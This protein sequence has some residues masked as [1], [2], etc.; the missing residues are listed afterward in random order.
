MNNAERYNAADVLLA[1]NVAGERAQRVAVIDD[2]R[3]Y[4]YGELNERVNRFSNLLRSRD[5]AP[6]ERLLLCLED[7]IDFPVCFL[8]ALRAGV[9]VPLNTLLTTKD[10]AYIVADSEAVGLVI[11][12]A[13]H[14]GWTPVL[15]ANPSLAVWSGGD[16]L[17]S[18]LHDCS[19]A[20]VTA[21]TRRGDV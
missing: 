7:S 21:P 6:R 20:E 15:E 3:T 13:L 18:A 5:I 12:P 14:T 17:L 9:V 16:A 8:G 4:T 19:D 11:S 1:P 2:T 10:Y